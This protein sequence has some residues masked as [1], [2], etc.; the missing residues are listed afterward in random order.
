MSSNSLNAGGGASL[1]GIHVNT[2]ESHLFV[3]Y[4]VAL[5]EQASVLLEAL[6]S[7]RLALD[8]ESIQNSGLLTRS[9]AQV[10][11]ALSPPDAAARPPFEPV[12]LLSDSN[13]SSLVKS[14]IK[15]FPDLNEAVKVSSGW[16]V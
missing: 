14:F 6:T 3:D 11:P 4:A 7:M 16:S 8:P 10:V 12:R 13:Y 15:K 9:L 2:A 1:G 5:V